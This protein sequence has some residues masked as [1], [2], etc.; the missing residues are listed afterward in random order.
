MRTRAKPPA[1]VSMWMLDV[2]CCALGCVTLLWLLNNRAASDETQRATQALADL[3]AAKA[4]LTD[5]DS[6][7]TQLNAQ[8]ADLQAK[9]IALARER[10][11]TA[12]KLAVATTDIATFAEK[13]AQSLGNAA[14]LDE[15]LRKKQTEAA[16]LTTS[17]DKAKLSAADTQKLLR[18]KEAERDDVALRAQKAESQLADADTRLK[19]MQKSTDDLATSRGQ[20]RD[21]QK[22]LDDANANI[23]DLQG[24]KKKLAD[25]IDRVR[26]D[27]DTRFAGIAMTG[28]RV[29]F[30]VD[31]S[32][33]MKLIDEKTAAPAKWPIVV[34]T[35]AKV[36]RSIPELE[37]VQV[38]TFS[39]KAQHVV[40]NGG[41]IDFRGESTVKEITG[42][43]AAVDP[44]GDT[45]LYDA[46]D[47]AFRLKDTG[48]D[49]VYLFSDG[50]PTSG[51]GLTPEQDKLPDTQRTELLARH[52]R[53]S[54]ATT[55]NRAPRAKIN[56]IGFF[57]ESPEVGAFLWALAREND[58]S[59]VGMSRP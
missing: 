6:S 32:G 45:N 58:G 41:W 22:K 44:V 31:I 20:L 2:F 48:L 56:A 12:G 49:T 46:F 7:R 47:L 27:S 30:L 40:G 15:M 24:D 42:A 17:L 9:L 39:R 38:I 18:Q 35:V 51:P 52:I 59:F 4:A 37:K 16:D 19:V 1:L 25:R 26:T 8:I 11:A 36:M 28:K 55:W 43:L 13:L 57:Y 23:I 33:S 3:N 14:A 54:L 10:D 50:L 5:A 21:I 29:A 34:E 53:R